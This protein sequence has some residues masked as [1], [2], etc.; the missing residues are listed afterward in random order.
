MYA[1]FD[2]PHPP[3]TPPAE[4]YEIYRDKKFPD[5]VTADWMETKLIKMRKKQHFS[6]NWEQWSGREDVIQESL[7]AFAACV[8]HI[9]S[10]IGQMI[11]TLRETGVLKN[12]WIFFIADHGDRCFDHQLMAKGNF[13]AGSTNV[14][15]VAVP[16]DTWL[17]KIDQDRIGFTDRS[18]AVGLQDILPTLCDLAGANIPEDIP[19]KSILPFFTESEPVWRETLCGTCTVNFGATDGKFKYCWQ[20][21]DGTEML[22]NLKEDPQRH[23]GSCRQN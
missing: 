3:L 20:G 11:G 9:D 10:R 18:H 6:Q 8:T 7:R 1:S 2:K 19:G 5:P 14:P 22:F 21:D 12:T 15:Y 17:E 13:L 4:F 23:S 16:S